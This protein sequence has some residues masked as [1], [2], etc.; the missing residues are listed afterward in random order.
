[1][2]RTLPTV[3]LFCLPAFAA[4]PQETGRDVEPVALQQRGGDGPGQ[5]RFGRRGEFRQSQR[6]QNGPPA[7]IAALDPNRD[8]VL[9][10]EEI[11]GA[12]RALL[13]LDKNGD[14]QLSREE[15]APRLNRDRVNQDRSERG[16]RERT[17]PPKPSAERDA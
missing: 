8:G 9:S 15:L 1:M 11:A 7:I 10:A 14:G 3:V 4:P 6:E 5:G 17:A 12:S 13:S 2:F 16:R